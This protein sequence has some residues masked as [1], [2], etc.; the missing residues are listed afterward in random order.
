M[1]ADPDRLSQIVINLLSNAIKAIDKGGNIGISAG[2][3]GTEVFIEVR[4]TGCGIK[5][6]D[7]PFIFERF[8]RTADGGLGLGLA[9]VKE[10][11]DAHGGRIEAASEYGKG[12]LFSVYLK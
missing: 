7:L 3:K 12:S 2:Q 8:Y 6:E 4:D 1:N 10:L 9:I 11:I 5:K